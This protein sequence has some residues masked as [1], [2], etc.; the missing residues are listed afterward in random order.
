MSESDMVDEAVRRLVGGADLRRVVEELRGQDQ[1]GRVRHDLGMPDDASARA[2]RRDL[3]RRGYD[4]VS[5]VYRDDRGESD[6]ASAETTSMYE[7]WIDELARQLAPGSRVLDIGCGAGVPA[8]QLLVEAGFDVVGVDISEVQIDRARVLVPQAIFVCSDLVDFVLE[9][10]SLDAVISLYALIHVPLEDQR[11]LFPRVFAALRPRGLLLVIVGHRR[12]SGVEDYLGAPM[13][14]DHAD[15]RTYLRW[16]DDEGFE[17][18]WHRFV[19]EGDVGHTLALARRPG[20][21]ELSEAEA[22]QVASEE[23]VAAR[24]QLRSLADR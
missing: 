21:D 11:T 13:F 8:D 10:G 9:P 12:W 14:W 20:D 22:Q 1:S 6:P 18:L 16:L 19:P 24:T 4:V 7:G 5:K 2:A 15:E 23:L 17:V 3:V